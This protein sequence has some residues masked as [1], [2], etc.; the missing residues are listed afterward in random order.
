MGNKKLA[1]LIALAV[2]AIAILMGILAYRTKPPADSATMGGNNFGV[3][4]SR[5]AQPIQTPAIS[6]ST[7]PEEPRYTT[8]EFETFT[9][10]FRS[11]LPTMKIL[12]AQ[13]KHAMHPGL[14]QA[15]SRSG[16]IA[17][18]AIRQPELREMAFSAL[19]YCTNLNGYDL[20]VRAMC[21]RQHRKIRSA[22]NDNSFDERN[23]IKNLNEISNLIER[24][25]SD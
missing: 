13:P 10:K 24:S 21:L 16:Q 23:R 9:Q 25:F 4:D 17:R 2:T 15:Y 1:S 12:R 20:S 11:E 14:M 18:A 5:D 8:R 22:I 6:D 19:E 7:P 3:Q